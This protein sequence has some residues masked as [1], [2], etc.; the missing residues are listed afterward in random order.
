MGDT[1]LLKQIQREMRTVLE[2]RLDPKDTGTGELE[3]T[4][5]EVLVWTP[6]DQESA[7]I[8][9][10]I[11][12]DAR[13]V[14]GTIEVYRVADLISCREAVARRALEGDQLA[15]KALLIITREMFRS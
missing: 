2:H 9:G 10:W 5:P 13:E 6:K 14:G 8:D 7:I 4:V 1:E 3:S 15:T 12:V 11:L